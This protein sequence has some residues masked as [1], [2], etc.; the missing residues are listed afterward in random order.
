MPAAGCLDH[1]KPSKCRY[2]L[3]ELFR[4]AEDNSVSIHSDIPA[5][6]PCI[7]LKYFISFMGTHKLEGDGLYFFLK[8]LFISHLFTFIQ[9]SGYAYI[10]INKKIVFAF[11][12]SLLPTF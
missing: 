3:S 6:D 9:T 7:L 8:R 4:I 10:F 1:S 12:D 2:F 5:S 11:L